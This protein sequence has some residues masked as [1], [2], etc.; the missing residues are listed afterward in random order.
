MRVRGG[1]AGGLQPPR[2]GHEMG[3]FSGTKCPNF[4]QLVIN[5]I[6]SAEH[7]VPEFYEFR[8]LEIL[9]N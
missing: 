8:S 4:G 9:G 3:E 7:E 1:G 2:F 5:K 6:C